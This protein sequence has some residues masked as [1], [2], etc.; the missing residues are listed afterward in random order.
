MHCL[1]VHSVLF[2]WPLCILFDFCLLLYSTFGFHSIV[3]EYLLD[4]SI[5]FYA[6]ILF[7]VSSLMNSILF[8]KHLLFLFYLSLLLQYILVLSL[9]LFY[10]WLLFY[11]IWSHSRCISSNPFYWILCTYS[12]LLL[13]QSIW[14]NSM[15]RF[16]SIS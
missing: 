5:Q 16:Y 10:V 6:S 13:L 3:R 9:I 15:H 11:T 12:I 7:C 14:F 1:L 4:H 8:F 2:C